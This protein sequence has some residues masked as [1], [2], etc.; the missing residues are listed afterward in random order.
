MQN[1]LLLENMCARLFRL[2]KE[3]ESSIQLFDLD[4]SKQ[5]V[6]TNHLNTVEPGL[7]GLTVTITNFHS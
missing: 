2:N 7:I 4:F 5:Q 1:S 3:Q 6:Q